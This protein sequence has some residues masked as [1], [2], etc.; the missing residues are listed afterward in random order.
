MVTRSL[1]YICL[2]QPF[3]PQ[4]IERI[5]PTVSQ[6][7]VGIEQPLNPVTA[8]VVSL[9]C[10]WWS[11]P[12]F[13]SG[14]LG[15]EVCR[16]NMAFNPSSKPW[17]RLKE[18]RIWPFFFQSLGLSSSSLMSVAHLSNSVLHTLHHHQNDPGSSS[19]QSWVTKQSQHTG[20]RCLNT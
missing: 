14:S 1:H 17:H 5:H 7:N 13:F 16:G 15:L 10:W 8:S 3:K 20:D 19:E 12:R 2:P 9:A 6:C 4:H 11:Q 18:C